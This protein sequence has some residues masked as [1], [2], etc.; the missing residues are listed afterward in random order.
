MEYPRRKRNRYACAHA[1]SSH[2]RRDESLP[3]DRRHLAQRSDAKSNRRRWCDRNGLCP[4]GLDEK[5]LSLGSR[6]QIECAVVDPEIG[7]RT[8]ETRAAAAPFPNCRI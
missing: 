3:D 2:A 7:G 5:N 8:R 6:R 1:T 4:G